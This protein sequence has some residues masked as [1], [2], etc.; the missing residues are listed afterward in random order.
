MRKKIVV[1]ICGTKRMSYLKLSNWLIILISLWLISLFR[2]FLLI[3]PLQ[4]VPRRRK[5]LKKFRR[6]MKRGINKV[7]KYKKQ[8]K[9]TAR[10]FKNLNKII[11]VSTAIKITLQYKLCK[12]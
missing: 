10:R 1:R 3:T 12:L 2:K 5:F 11:D 7:K 4:K 9:F 6:C 8:C